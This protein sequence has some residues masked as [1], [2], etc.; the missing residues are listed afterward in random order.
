MWKWIGI[1]LVNLVYSLPCIRASRIVIWVGGMNSQEAVNGTYIFEPNINDER[2]PPFLRY[3]ARQVRC[4][5][6][7]PAVWKVSS[8]S[9]SNHL[10]RGRLFFFVLFFPAFVDLSAVA[11][12]LFA[13]VAFPPPLSSPSFQCFY[14][15]SVQSF[16]PQRW[17]DFVASVTFIW[18]NRSRS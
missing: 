6:W 17:D 16:R 4:S 9:S 2:S 10:H 3:L 5:G 18:V 8:P 15:E 13:D 7:K 12:S 11:R 1:R 14:D